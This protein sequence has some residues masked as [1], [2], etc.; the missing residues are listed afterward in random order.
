[1][2]TETC[3][4]NR[5]LKAILSINLSTGVRDLHMNVLIPTG[6]TEISRQFS[7][8]LLRRTVEN[9]ISS[10]YKAEESG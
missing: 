2:H 1:M 3:G 5:S 7:V 6:E 10:A 4:G 8:L 9:L